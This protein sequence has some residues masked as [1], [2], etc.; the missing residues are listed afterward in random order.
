MDEYIAKPIRA[1][2]LFQTLA[3]VMGF[4]SEPLSVPNLP[5]GQPAAPGR[6]RQPALVWNPDTALDSVKGDQDLLRIVIET[7]LEE[8]PLL[9][10]RMHESLD[11]S[12]GADLNMAA[13]SLKGSLRFL[14]AE[15]GFQL[16]YQLELMGRDG[17]FE[18]APDVLESLESF[19]A[20][21]TPSLRTY[22]E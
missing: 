9:V 16:A 4:S 20:K 12:K 3:N 14:G 2:Q 6:P 13:H 19:L 18:K 5:S 21:L 11:Q 7:Y 1:K 17:D 8:A 15:Q 10:T 22:L